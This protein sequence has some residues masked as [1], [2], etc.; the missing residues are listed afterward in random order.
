MTRSWG[1]T[2]FAVKCMPRETAI[3]RD[4]VLQKQRVQR[5][6]GLRRLTL[7]VPHIETEVDYHDLVMAMVPKCSITDA[8]M[9]VSPDVRFRMKQGFDPEWKSSRVPRGLPGD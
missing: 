5:I 3:K 2:V 4:K 7:G 8:K 9:S 1:P 6:F